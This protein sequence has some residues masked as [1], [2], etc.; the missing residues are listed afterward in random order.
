MYKMLCKEID[1]A[2]RCGEIN[3]EEIERLKKKFLLPIRLNEEANEQ[4]AYLLIKG[5]EEGIT[6]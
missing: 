3:R 1:Y 6:Q 2:K 5:L 4:K